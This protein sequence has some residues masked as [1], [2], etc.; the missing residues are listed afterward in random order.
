MTEYYTEITATIYYTI[1]KNHPDR[2]YM[3]DRG[4]SI[5]RTFTDTY[6]FPTEEKKKCLV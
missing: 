1:D 5:I 3:N 6:L 4:T 2:K